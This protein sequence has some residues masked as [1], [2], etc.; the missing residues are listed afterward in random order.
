MKELNLTLN[1]ATKELILRTGE[2]EKIVYPKGI[3]ITGILA[4]PHQFYEG[5][6]P[7]AKDCHIQIQKDLGVI[8]L[9][10]LDTDPHSSS[11]I[12]GRLTKDTYFNQ[13]GIN[14][15]KRWTVS[16]FLKHIKMMRSFFSEKTECDAM[17][18]SLQ[19]WNARVEVVMKQH[20]DNSGNSL[21]MLER[22]V[23][24]I[25][26]KTKFSLT[27]P[28]FQGYPKQKFTVEVGLDP[29]SNAVDLYLFSNDLFQLEIEHRGK[30][31]EEE[32]AKFADFDCSKV[33]IS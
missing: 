21:S 33:V 4:A 28:I 19:K 20:N 30:L 8:S 26:L 5:K 24:D 11:T 14:T 6:K 16:A 18:N 7:E 27:I 29:K 15:E 22:T 13:W 31:I 12:T 23:S 9:F 1:E 2:A 25:E 17:V 3:S 10:I 32:L